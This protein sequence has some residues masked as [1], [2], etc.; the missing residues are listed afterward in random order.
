M[1]LFSCPSCD[2]VV[3]FTNTVCERCGHALGYEPLTN[4]MLALEPDG[5]YFVSVGRRANGEHWKYCDNYRY[6]VCNWLLPSDSPETLSIASRFNLTVPDLSD[7]QNVALWQK[8][9]FAK[10]RL[11]YSLLRLKLPLM[12]RAEDPE[13][14]GFDFLTHDPETGGNVMTGHDRGL[15]T[16]ALAEADDAERE[17]RR[18]ELGEPY[19]TLLG[20][21]RHE[22]G[23]WY[24]DRLVRDG[25]ALE[26]C[27]AVFGDDSQDYGQALQT[28][29][30]NGP[31]PNWQDNF[32][33][34][35]AGAH[36]WEDFAETWAHY[37]HIVDTLE[38]G[39]AL[40]MTLSPRL[41]RDGI[42][43]TELDFDIYGQSTTIDQ[44]AEAWL[45]L[46]AAINALNRS[47]GLNDAYPFVLSPVVIQKLGFIHDLVHG[48]IGT[49]ARAGL[50]EELV[51]SQQPE[52]AAG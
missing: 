36:P 10:Q 23:H 40:G 31:Q 5:Q 29:Y 32:V 1:K 27:R 46:S 7:P 35:Y 37:L 48:R 24:W 16:I 11:F 52:T 15:I 44:I 6:G 22:V 34:S 43:T 12:T 39:G 28:H 4:R 20:H 14:L 2:Q 38:T 26:A 30:A 18:A 13:G 25:N 9:E 50:S 21:M 19:R 8:M 51:E 33:S 17:K 47:M 45:A 3:Y 49:A 42:L 41:D